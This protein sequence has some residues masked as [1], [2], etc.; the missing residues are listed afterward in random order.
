MTVSM[1]EYLE[2]SLGVW[3]GTYTHLSPTGEV[4][5]TF[6]SRQELRLDGPLWYERLVHRPG[7][8]QERISDFRGRLADDGT[9]DLGM[10]GFTGTATVLDDRA[11]FFTGH[12]QETGVR[13]D[14]LV[15]MVT[16]DEKLRLWQRFEGDTLIGISVIRETRRADGVPADWR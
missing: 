14:E 2:R 6:D 3:D 7:T 5:E 16:S 9:L 11:L 10:A 15:T 1:R 8:A 13:V 12:W 4:I